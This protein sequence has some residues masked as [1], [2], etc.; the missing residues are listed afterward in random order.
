[1]LSILIPIHNYNVIALIQTLQLQI[2]NVD[3]KIEVICC[4]DASTNI[5][6]Q[7]KNAAFLKTQNIKLIKN[8]TNVGRTQTRQILTNSAQFDWLLFLDADVIPVQPTFLKTYISYL[9]QKY[10]CVYGGLS[11]SKVQPS[12]EYF[13]RWLYG[14]K[15]EDILLSKRKTAPYKSIAS[16]N[17]LIRKNLFSSINKT[18]SHNWYGYDNFFS[19]Q[20]KTNNNSI[21]HINNKV[22]HIG[23]EDNRNFLKKQEQATETIYRLYVN[24]HFANTQDNGLLKTYLQ[25]KKY[26]LIWAYNSF[27]KVFKKHL[28]HNLLHNNPKLFYLDLYR[29]GYF[30]ELTTQKHA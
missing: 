18:I 20:L 3:E 1:M 23:L 15:R 11:Y 24:R 30:C 25:L 9:Q 29:L 5:E 12:K 16:G 28:K 13:F 21:E 6:L 22:Y 14:H 26:K 27:Y 19:T 17:L 10:D 8:Q 2:E 4:D 7:K